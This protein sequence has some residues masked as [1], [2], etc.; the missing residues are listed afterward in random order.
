MTIKCN[1]P[2]DWILEWG[3]IKIKNI[4]IHTYT[5]DILEITVRGEVSSGLQL[6]FK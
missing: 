4:H 5:Q 1:V 3:K 6:T 2:L